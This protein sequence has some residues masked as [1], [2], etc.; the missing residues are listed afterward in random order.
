MPTGTNH[1]HDQPSHLVLNNPGLP[2]VVNLP[3]YDGPEA[4]WA[5]YCLCAG[6]V[7]VLGWVDHWA[8]RWGLSA[9][10]MHV[11]GCSLLTL[12][13]CPTKLERVGGLNS[14]VLTPCCRCR[15]LLLCVSQTTVMTP[16]NALT[17][18]HTLQVL[19]CWGV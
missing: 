10:G 7:E 13:L 9:G 17:L 3:H 14:G 6:L 16:N 2:S 19:P 11:Q 12:W 8:Q 5:W 4:R 18:K 15:P 1:D